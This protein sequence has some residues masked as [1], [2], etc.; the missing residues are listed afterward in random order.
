MWK[1]SEDRFAMIW[2]LYNIFFVGQE[3]SIKGQIHG[4]SRQ[5]LSNCCKTKPSVIEKASKGYWISST[6]CVGINRGIRRCGKYSKPSR[7]CQYKAS[8]QL[9][10]NCLKHS[11]HIV[12]DDCHDLLVSSHSMAQHQTNC[13]RR[14]FTARIC[15][16]VNLLTY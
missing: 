4:N 8:L 14:F 2:S 5:N 11:K 7:C 15:V 10:Y 6:R 13:N 1:I 3:H 9:K 16:L 12:P